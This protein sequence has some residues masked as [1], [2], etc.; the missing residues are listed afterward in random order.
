MRLRVLALLVTA[1]FACACASTGDPAKDVLR[2]EV[3]S[4][5]CKSQCPVL[6]VLALRAC[7]EISAEKE[8]ALHGLCV[9]EAK[10]V[11]VVCPLLCDEIRRV[12]VAE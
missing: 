10:A 6:L 11:S 7:D 3:V 1:L 4:V 2:R 12:A 8:P 9:D 5:V